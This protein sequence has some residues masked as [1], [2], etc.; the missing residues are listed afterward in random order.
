MK[1]F[2]RKTKTSSSA[3]LLCIL[4]T[5]GANLAQADSIQSYSFP[6]RYIAHAGETPSLLVADGDE[7]SNGQWNV[8]PG[9]ADSNCVSFESAYSSNYYLRHYYYNLVLMENTGE[10][11]FQEDATFC[12]R[13]GLASSSDV[14]FES[15]NVPGY[16]IKHT[17]FELSVAELDSSSSVA[18]QGDATFRITNNNAGSFGI[19]SGRTYYIKNRNSDKCL[20]SLGGSDADAASV[21]QYTCGTNEFEQW[22]VNSIGNGQYNI[23]Q[24]S[25]GK[26]ADISGA[27]TAKGGNNI[28]WPSNGGGNQ[29]WRIEPQGGNYYH[30]VNVHSNL[31]LDISD[32]SLAD[33]GNNIQWPN[34]DGYN[35][36]WEFVD[37]NGGSASSDFASNPILSQETVD[38]ADPDIIHHNGRFYMYPTTVPTR[39]W[40]STDMHVYSSADLINW[41]DDGVIVSANNFSWEDTKFWAPAIEERDGKFYFYFSLNHNVAVAVADSPTGPFTDPIGGPLV[42][43]HIDP[44]VFIDDDGQA[45]LYYGQGY[46]RVRRLNSDMVST[47]GGEIAL[48]APNMREGVYMFKREGKYY[49]SWSVDDARSDNY[50]VE[51]SI[52]DS[53]LGPFEYQGVLLEKAANLVGTGHHSIIQMPDSDD[54]YIVYHRHFVPDGGGQ[55]REIATQKMTFN[56]DGTIQRVVPQ[57]TF[58]IPTL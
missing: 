21:V 19:V 49:M 53:P 23:V 42:S 38:L 3:L 26:Y 12:Q 22:T 52:G 16:Y 4:S 28:I 27:S 24:V 18:D 32:E 46:P 41:R 8:V 37:V 1:P 14:S 2:R 33:N 56:S 7:Q 6:D 50:H 20:R 57:H 39:D 5:V 58:K 9:L 31:L 11:I 36:D 29:K 34:N 48:E 35:Q 30:I 55:Y 43:G 17:D 51:Y 25:S 45:Y 40:L 44:D 10:S 15:Y 13:P 47:T 54:W